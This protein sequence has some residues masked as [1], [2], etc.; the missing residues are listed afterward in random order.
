MPRFCRRSTSTRLPLRLI[1]MQRQVR[2]PSINQVTKNA[3][4]LQTQYIDKVAATPYCD[5]ATGSVDRRST[6]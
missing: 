6:R 2:R 3:E 1:V 5:A 4:I